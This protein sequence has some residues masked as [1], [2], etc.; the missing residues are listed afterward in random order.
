M[1]RD[2]EMI[3]RIRSMPISDDSGPLPSDV[4]NFT[5]SE[6]RRELESLR[7]TRCHRV[8]D[9]DAVA[10]GWNAAIDFVRAEIDRRLAALGS[11]EQPESK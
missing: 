8:V 7:E 4:A 3:E 9:G 1:S 2:D 5:C 6:I 11:T 10:N